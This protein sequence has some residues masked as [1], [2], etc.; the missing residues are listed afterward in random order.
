M[1]TI[2]KRLQVPLFS[3]LVAVALGFGARQAAATPA[4]ACGPGAHTTCSSKSACEAFCT[5]LF[6]NPGQH[7]CDNGCCFC[8]E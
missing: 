8:A 2:R 7:I 5:P 1:R 3:L 4:K 6:G